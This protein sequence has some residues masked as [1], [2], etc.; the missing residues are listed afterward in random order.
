MWFVKNYLAILFSFIHALF[1]VL[2]GLNS[3]NYLFL[4]ALF[5]L[6]FYFL[7]PFKNEN[8]NLKDVLIHC[9]FFSIG[10]YLT[11]FAQQY[12]PSVIAAAIVAGLFCLLPDIKKA[13]LKSFIAFKEFENVLY[14]GCFAGMTKI[15]WFPNYYLTILTCLLGGL[16]YSILSK[17]LIGFGGKLGT[18]GFASVIVYLFFQ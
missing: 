14:A 15:E 11:Q 3:N 13:N 7:L 16:M 18:I 9:V 8:I 12:I 1:F 2:I 4:F 17:S 5:I 10:F 6:P